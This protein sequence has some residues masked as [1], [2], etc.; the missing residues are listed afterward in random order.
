MASALER[1]LAKVRGNDDGGAMRLEKRV[2]V[3]DSILYSANKAA[4][5]DVQTLYIRASSGLEILIQNDRRLLPFRDSLFSN[6]SKDFELEMQTPDV[7]SEL[8]VTITSFLRIL[9]PQ[10]TNPASYEV[11]K[12]VQSVTN[13][14][15]HIFFICHT[16]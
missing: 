3:R 16:F 15:F 13:L 12:N 5:I 7:I 1:Q 4:E 6:K 8:K 10:L 11:S 2:L 9:A 14:Y